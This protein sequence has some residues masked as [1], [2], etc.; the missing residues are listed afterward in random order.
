MGL[1]RW[2]DRGGHIRMALQSYRNP[3][4]KQG[5][6]I[7]LVCNNSGEKLGIVQEIRIDLY[8][9]TITQTIYDW[10]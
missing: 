10:L 5:S 3:F 1:F 2:S 4:D 6:V 9:D 7:S 8:S